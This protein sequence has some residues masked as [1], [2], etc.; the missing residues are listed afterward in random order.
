MFINW[1]ACMASRH[2]YIATS[3]KITLKN[4]LMWIEKRIV[5]RLRIT[6]EPRY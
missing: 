5:V 6:V 4:T 3:L 1:H 2:R